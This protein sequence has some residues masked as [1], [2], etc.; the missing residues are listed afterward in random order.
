MGFNATQRVSFGEYVIHG[1]GIR[2]TQVRDRVN[3]G[4]G[5]GKTWDR[6]WGNTGRGLGDTCGV[7]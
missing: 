4:W 1:S 7:F 2:V 3:K 5:L 6:D